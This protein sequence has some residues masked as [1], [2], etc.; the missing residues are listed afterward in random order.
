MSTEFLSDSSIS[1]IGRLQSVPLRQ[2]WKHE[3]HDFTPWLQEN[4]DVLS[5]AVGFS[6]FDARRECS[7]GSFSVDLVAREE[8]SDYLVVI[9]NQLCPSDHDHLGKLIT[10]LTAVEEALTAIW[11][12]SHAREE[13]VEAVKWLNRSTQNYFYLLQIEAVRIGNSEPAPILKVLI[14]GEQ[15][16]Q[17]YQELTE[18]AWEDDEDHYRR[19]A[20]FEMLLG[21]KG[22]HHC[23]LAQKLLDWS[24][25]SA[26]WVWWGKGEKRC[27]F[28][29]MIRHN[30]ISHQ[31]FVVWTSGRI[32]FCFRWYKSKFPFNAE[33]K[34]LALLH[35]LNQIPSV[36]LSEDAITGAP[37]VDI[38]I[39]ED[40]A[41]LNQLA[42]IFSWFVQEVRQIE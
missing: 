25:T 28:I 19:K 8:T 10:Y 34:R 4:L 20:F 36:E 26:D 41:C 22:K 30:D 2:V 1:N 32:E 33:E 7:T 14:D 40:E 3:A 12:V 13:H 35:K 18:D 23:I 21:R 24:E 6:I 37:S 11:I 9:E 5:E 38:G 27:S 31:L 39:F 42:E 16:K 17:I 29:P 15:E